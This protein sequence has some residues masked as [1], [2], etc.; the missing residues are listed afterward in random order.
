M[1][2]EQGGHIRNGIDTEPP[3]STYVLGNDLALI[4]MTEETI[5]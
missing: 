1:V 5:S 4:L 3:F 2:F